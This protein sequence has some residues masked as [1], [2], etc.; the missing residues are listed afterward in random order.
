MAISV[1]CVAVMRPPSTRIG[2]LYGGYMLGSLC[3]GATST[4]LLAATFGGCGRLRGGEGE[5]PCARPGICA[6]PTPSVTQRRHSACM[7]SLV[8]PAAHHCTLNARPMRQ[9]HGQGD[10]AIRGRNGAEGSTCF[11]P[12][13]KDLGRYSARSCAQPGD[14][15][16]AEEGSADKD[17]RVPPPPLAAISAGWAP[18]KEGS[19]THTTLPSGPITAMPVGTELYLSMCM[20]WG[21]V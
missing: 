12:W 15:G 5:F 8:L 21:G 13:A 20:L 14:D 4:G 17:S 16:A 6:V 2:G 11:L 9:A 19:C 10:R 7:Q 1:S 3:S 18:M